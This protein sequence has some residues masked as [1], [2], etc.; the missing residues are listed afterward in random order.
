MR[1]VPEIVK[2]DA[3][4]RPPRRPCPLRLTI[5]FDCGFAADTVFSSQ[6]MRPVMQ[7]RRDNPRRKTFLG[8]RIILK[9]MQTSVDCVIRDMDAGGARL[10]CS[11]VASLPSRFEIEI[12]Q[13]SRTYLARIAWRDA[14]S[15]GI[16]FLAPSSRRPKT[17]A[18]GTGDLAARVRRLEADKARLQSRVAQLTGAL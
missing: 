6:M 11:D 10:A 14:G 4:G 16:S 1:P 8:G 13:T 15:A 17:G 9:T 5:G 2:T 18:D 12:P 7:E 3:P